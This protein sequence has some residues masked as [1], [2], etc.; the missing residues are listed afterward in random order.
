LEKSNSGK[1]GNLDDIMNM[2]KKSGNISDKGFVN[3][4]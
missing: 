2:G 3:M 1:D 4:K